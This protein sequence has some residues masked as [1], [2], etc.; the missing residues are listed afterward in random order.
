MDQTDLRAEEFLQIL[1]AI[2]RRG[3]I[4]LLAALDKGADPID[5]RAGFYGPP[6]PGDDFVDAF[7]IDRPRVDLLASRRLFPQVRKVHV[8]EKS[9]SQSARDR[10]RRHGQH[11][12]GLALFAKRQPLVDAETMLF[13]DHREAEA[14][15]DD[16]V[17]NQG[18]GADDDV[19]RAA[20][21]SFE[22]RAAFA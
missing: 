13:V 4:G 8:A 5:P 12:N 14:G 2:L 22:R 19:Q 18:M 17:L 15:E 10:S 16:I 7:D 6:K 20:R 21:Q 1:G 9:Q 3:Q 11:V